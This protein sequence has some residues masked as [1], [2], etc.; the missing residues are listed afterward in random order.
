MGIQG[1]VRVGEANRAGSSQDAGRLK[2]A[3]KH[4][5]LNVR[6]YVDDVERQHRPARLHSA[7]SDNVCLAFFLGAIQ[8]FWIVAHILSLH[9][10]LPITV[11]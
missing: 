7:F 10:E 2:P 3:G 6:P 8:V 9:S 4:H 11:S 1:L 5:E